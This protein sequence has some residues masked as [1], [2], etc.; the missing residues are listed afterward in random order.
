MSPR[1]LWPLALLALLYWEANRIVPYCSKLARMGIVGT[2]VL[3]LPYLVY[4]TL[5]GV[6]WWSP[7]QSAQ[8]TIVAGLGYAGMFVGFLSAAICFLLDAKRRP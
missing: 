5:H 1:P 4:A 6:P 3:L 8:A 2:A 7:E